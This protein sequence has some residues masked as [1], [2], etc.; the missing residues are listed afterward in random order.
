MFPDIAVDDCEYTDAIERDRYKQ[1]AA[2]VI[3]RAVRDWKTIAAGHTE[4]A[5][6]NRREIRQFFRSDYGTGICDLFDLDSRDVLRQL[7]RG[8]DWIPYHWGCFQ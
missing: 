1:L 2:L 4:T 3:L 6:S 5:K 7:E 8:V